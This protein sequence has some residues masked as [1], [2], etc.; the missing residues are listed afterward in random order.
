MTYLLDTRI[1]AELASQN[2]D[3]QVVRWL[4]AQPEETVFISVVTLAEISEN[5]E[6]QH[7]ESQKANLL[8]WL[9]N[10]LIVRFGGRIS[11]I[12]IAVSLKWGEV[13]T[14]CKSLGKALSLPD[15]LSLAIAL[16]YDHTLVT[17]DI[18]LFEDT[19]VKAISPYDQTQI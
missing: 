9:H 4:D 11:E 2:P 16:V 18:D 7:S 19:G 3:P 17:R 6:S 5:I 14:K 13:I 8:S 1:I 15:S 10:D 12:T